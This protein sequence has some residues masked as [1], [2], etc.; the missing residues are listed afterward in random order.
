MLQDPGEWKTAVRISYCCAVS[1]ILNSF[2]FMLIT[3]SGSERER[4]S[5]AVGLSTRLSD[6]IFIIN[7]YIF[8]ITIII[9]TTRPSDMIRRAVLHTGGPGEGAGGMIIPEQYNVPT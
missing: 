6:Y 3:S 2:I 5:P 1:G 7:N 4:E 9:N 8:I